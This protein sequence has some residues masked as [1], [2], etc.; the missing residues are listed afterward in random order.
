[1]TT[2]PTPISSE[3]LALYLAGE[4]TEA[5]RNEVESWAAAS[6][7][8]ASELL[9]M[10]QL[11]DLSGETTAQP[12]VD[13]DAAWMKLE[14]RIAE[15]EGRGI[16]R[17][18]GSAS[19]WTR[20]IAAAAVITGLVFAARWFM[21]PQAEHYAA[22]HEAVEVLLSDNSR[23]VLSPGSSLE[24]RMGKQRN[25][26]LTGAAYFE[27]QR[28]EQRPFTVESG[29]V[30][31]TVLG[32][33]FE[34][35]AFDTARTIVVRVRSGRVRVDVGGESVELSAGEHAVYNKERHFLERRTAPPAEAWGLRILQFEDATLDQVAEQLQ[36]IYKVRIDLRNESIARCTLTAEFDD[37]PLRTILSVIAETFGLAVEEERG[38][39]TLDGDGC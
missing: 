3:L 28:Y 32:T 24:V 36:R 1:M 5:Q 11:W 12:E 18:I 33:A 34:V 9:R 8:N 23:S 2:D 19:S 13:V 26:Q 25:V 38:T 27:V 22:M 6:D 4:A 30:L 31:V 17:P 39:Y 37:E 10:Q 35:S 29:D 14:A 15:T 16:V 21:Q 7:A 20:W